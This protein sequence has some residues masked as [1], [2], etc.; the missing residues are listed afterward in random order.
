MSIRVFNADDHPILRKGIIDLLVETDGLDWIGSA[1]DGTEA[2]DKI[3]SLKPDV[4]VLDIEMPGFSGIQLAEKIYQGGLSTKVVLLTLFKEPGFIKQALGLGV[5]G[6]LLKESK[7]SEILDC[8]RSV[9]EGKRYVSPAL[10]QVLMDL[11]Q[12]PAPSLIDVLTEHEINIIKLIAK[13]KT[14]NEIAE[15]LFLSP[16]TISNHRSNISKKLQLDGQQNALLKWV[17]ENK[18]L[19]E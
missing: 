12:S 1:G 15:M 16:K 6:Y 13:N 11:N 3:R 7:E 8:I 17:M 4:A 14:S 18:G 10:T 9:A 2:W 19:F 5:H